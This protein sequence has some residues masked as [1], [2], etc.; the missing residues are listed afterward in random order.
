MPKVS[1]KL[2]GQFWENV[3][4]S[5]F[6]QDRNTTNSTC[7]TKTHLASPCTQETNADLPVLVQVGIQSVVA[8]RNVVEQRRTGWVVIR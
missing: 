5:K 4:T 1:Q 8:V 7:P 3:V 2:Q 6:H